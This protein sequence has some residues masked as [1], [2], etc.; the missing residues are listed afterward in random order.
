MIDFEHPPPPPLPS[1]LNHS[2]AAG[3]GS[4]KGVLVILIVGLVIMLAR[5]R[6]HL[7]RAVS[8]VKCDAILLLGLTTSGRTLS[9]L[10]E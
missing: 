1:L 5:S 3:L 9:A 10:A 4:T 6:K 2:L 7:C 8:P